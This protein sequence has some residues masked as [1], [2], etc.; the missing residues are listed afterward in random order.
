MTIKSQTTPDCY[1]NF[2]RKNLESF[3]SDQNFSQT[4]TSNHIV[5]RVSK[6]D[7]HAYARLRKY[8][9]N[10]RKIL[11]FEH[12]TI[13]VTSSNLILLIL[14]HFVCVIWPFQHIFM[15]TFFLAQYFVC[16]MKIAY[17]KSDSV[18]HS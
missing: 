16:A 2:E 11:A 7:R 8:F 4:I 10:L 9:H 6:S 15:H 5:S 17:R 1:R 3:C 18:T 14:T 12:K 13:K